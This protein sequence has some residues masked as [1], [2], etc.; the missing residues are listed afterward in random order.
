MRKHTIAW[1]VIGLLAL[2]AL[3]CNLSG[4]ASLVATPAPD[5]PAEEPTAVVIVLTPT[6]L[7]PELAGQT[8]IEEQLV[9]DV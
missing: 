1:F 3:A 9:I 2:S 8:D 4:L 7:P 6:P 5:A